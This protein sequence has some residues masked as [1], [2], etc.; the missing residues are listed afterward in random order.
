MKVTRPQGRR[1]RLALATSVAALAG[2]VSIFA[3]PAAAS[4]AAGFK[5]GNFAPGNLL[6]T[7]GVWTTNADITAGTTQL[8]P[9]A[10]DVALADGA[11]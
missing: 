8:P 7:T 2:S 9:P 5:P 10:V 11:I 6:V 4:A 1:R 3:V